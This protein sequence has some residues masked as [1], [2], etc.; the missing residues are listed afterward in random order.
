MT[1]DRREQEPG[2]P[3]GRP[4]RRSSAHFQRSRVAEPGTFWTTAAPWPR[5]PRDSLWLICR[6]IVCVFICVGLCLRCF[7][8]D[9]FVL[10]VLDVVVWM[11]IWFI[12]D[13][14]VLSCLL[15]CFTIISRR[16]R[17]L[18]DKMSL[19]IRQTLVWRLGDRKRGDEKR[20]DRKI[21]FVCVCLLCISVYLSYPPFSH[22]PFYVLPR[23]TL[24]W[25][26]QMLRTHTYTYIH[27]YMYICIYVYLYIYIY[28]YTHICIYVHIHICVYIY[29]YIC[30][31]IYTHVCIYTGSR[32]GVA[33]RSQ[34]REDLFGRLNGE[35]IIIIIII[36]ISSSS[37][38]SIIIVILVV[39]VIIVIVVI[40]ISDNSNN[41]NNIVYSSHDSSNNNNNNNNSLNGLLNVLLSVRQGH[42]AGLRWG[43]LTSTRPRK[44]HSHR[45][46]HPRRMAMAQAMCHRRSYLTGVW[47]NQGQ[48]MGRQQDSATEWLRLGG[49]QSPGW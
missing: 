8:L 37:S 19:P 26:A 9:V 16:P 1:A 48:D 11:L 47:L 27:R 25:R 31:Y 38:S 7:I 22:P 21:K 3:P 4:K 13:V 41:S 46:P 45:Q 6:Y 49:C 20:G 42:E 12:C 34:L 24:V 18:F 10:F 29:I 35:V 32:P 28:I 44:G 30:V 43:R 15:T 14:L 5:R 2:G 17:H 33:R 23:Q 39:I 36:I 40:T